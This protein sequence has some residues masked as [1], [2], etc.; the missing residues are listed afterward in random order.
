MQDYSGLLGPITIYQGPLASVGSTLLWPC[1]VRLPRSLSIFGVH[2]GRC[3]RRPAGSV[4]AAGAVVKQ[5]HLRALTC[6]TQLSYSGLSQAVGP[7]HAT[8]HSPS[9]GT[10]PRYGN[11][12]K[13]ETIPKLES[14]SKTVKFSPARASFEPLGLQ[15]PRKMFLPSIRAVKASKVVPVVPWYGPLLRDPP[16]TGRKSIVNHLQSRGRWFGPF[17]GW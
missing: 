6:G 3:A 8:G 11:V 10:I 14:V 1:W 7:S 4:H 12:P 15:K 2:R 5:L 9:H 16:V 13:H 17:Y